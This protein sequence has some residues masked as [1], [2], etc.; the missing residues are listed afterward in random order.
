MKTLF[1]MAILLL[2]LLGQMETKAQ[3]CSANFQVSVS[4]YTVTLYDS[5][6]T[7][8]NANSAYNRWTFGDGQST[9]W[10]QL[11]NATHTYN[12]PGTYTICDSVMAFYNGTLV[13]TDVY[14]QTV[15]ITGAIN[16]GNCA[17]NANFVYTYN[18]NVLVVTASG[19]PPT[20]AISWNV[21]GVT[22]SP[23][24]NSLSYTFTGVQTG[25]ASICL[26][27]YNSST[28][29]PCDTLCRN[30]VLQ[31]T[32]CSLNSDF[33]MFLVS[34]L[35][36]NTYSFSPVTTT[37]SHQWY[38]NGVQV[39]TSVSP[40]Y[41][42]PSDTTTRT[43]QVCHI[44]YEPGTT[45]FD[46]TCNS[47]TITGTGGTPCSGFSANFTQLQGPSITY[48]LTAN[49]TGGTP[50]FV[51]LWSD[52][53]TA[54]TTTTASGGFYC[55]TV[56][57]NMQC[58]AVFC[59]SVGGNTNPGCAVTFTYNVMGTN[60]VQ[61][62][63][64]S[65]SAAVSWLWSF[66]DGSGATSMN[67]IHTYAQ[68]GTYQVCLTITT[69][70]GCTANYC[71]V[72]IVNTSGATGTIC[73]IVFNDLNNN[74]VQDLGET[75][76]GGAFIRSS[77]TSGVYTD[78]SGLYNMIV[79][80][81]TYNIYYCASNGYIFSIPVV[82]L[83]N[84][85]AC[86]A[87]TVTVTAGSTSCGYNFGV[88]NNSVQICGTVYFDINNNGV[89]DSGENGMAHVQV[90]ISGSGATG[91]TYTD[92]LGNYCFTRAA[93]SYT[94]TVPP[95]AYQGGSIQPSSIS[96]AAT[97]TGSYYSNNN[98]GIYFQPGSCNL[99]VNL[100]PHTTVTAG[101]AAWYDVVVT[102]VGNS[103]TSG[104]LSMFYDPALVFTSSSPAQ[105]AHNASTRTITWNLGALYPGQQVS[106]WVNFNALS[107][108]QIGYNAFNLVNVVTNGC[109]DVNLNN[110]V[111]TVHQVATS[112]WDPNNKLV[113][114]IGIGEEGRISA[115][116]TVY[117][118][119]NFQNTGT[120][121]AVNI[122][123]RDE[124]SNQLDLSTFRMLESSHPYTL[125][126]EGSELVWKF[127]N[128]MLP[129]STTDEPNSHGFVRFSINQKSDL[130]QGTTIENT[131][132]IYFDFN[133]A[134]ITNTTLN[135]IDYNLGV[136]DL[137]GGVGVTIMPN[138]FRDYTTIKIAGDNGDNVKLEVMSIL[139]EV[140]MAQKSSNG[141]FTINRG[142]LPAGV[143]L[144]R[145]V[146]STR[147]IAKGKL[148]AE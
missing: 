33:T 130:T 26:Y 139:G 87:Y 121:P 60:T 2:A 132:G 25:S 94:V 19:V 28:S 137:S 144:Y 116:E 124:I 6:Y 143:Y 72:V 47:I 115:N 36:N 15:T 40:N 112:S 18:N 46:S 7:T 48:E 27:V 119:V 104:T 86:A 29:A 24:A 67:P 56:Y 98:F 38:V 133:E 142:G 5:T 9:A 79:P 1:K 107:S 44:V 114:P 43:Y 90:N 54:Q 125:Q 35:A 41:T 89:M 111:D 103:V 49:T 77:G 14:C 10:Q 51:Y 16:T 140:V 80:A 92:Q 64:T 85:S 70:N 65:N 17:P 74:G 42:F 32:G 13:C 131:A 108:T 21:N 55:L 105:S 4:G 99:S 78:S 110:N 62:V 100:T 34:G 127:S 82:G 123:L 91:V 113:E 31:N 73:G 97:T 96:V 135:T 61:F 22:T 58:S 109:N 30:V 45:C 23:T 57:D 81:G 95:S 122:V 84:S 126:I 37:S 63:S 117:Y 129:D 138:P 128:I 101:F 52:G 146:S 88:Y 141:I 59:D 69:A 39:S 106:Y 11:G 12:A 75:G 68:S 147:E 20:Y 93:G 53:S 118:T 145:V 66:G 76:I 50:P 8:P 3:A 134:V 102:N 71:G 83:A 136:D 120:A 148:I